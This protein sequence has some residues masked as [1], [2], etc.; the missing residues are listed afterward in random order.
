MRDAA[1]LPRVVAAGLLQQVAEVRMGQFRSA[2]GPPRSATISLDQGAVVTDVGDDMGHFSEPWVSHIMRGLRSAAPRW[3]A[4][5]AQ[6]DAVEVD[7]PV[8]L[9]GVVIV[10]APRGAPNG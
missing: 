1:S 6:G 5:L 10:R 7:L 9:A 3:L 8:G 4:A 2:S